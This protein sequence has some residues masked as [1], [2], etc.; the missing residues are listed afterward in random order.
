[1]NLRQRLFRRRVCVDIFAVDHD[2]M[3]V[4]RSGVKEI[5]ARLEEILDVAQSVARIVERVL[6][7]DYALNERVI[8]LLLGEKVF[9]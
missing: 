6:P 2:V 5:D 7:V 8:I 4:F 3:H 9:N 1:M